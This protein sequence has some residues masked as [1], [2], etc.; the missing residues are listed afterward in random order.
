MIP[1]ISKCEIKIMMEIKFS[2]KSSI[3][4]RN[5]IIILMVHLWCT[6]SQK[7]EGNDNFMQLK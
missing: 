2:Y 4:N 5:R 6:I 7:M 1:F 3:Q